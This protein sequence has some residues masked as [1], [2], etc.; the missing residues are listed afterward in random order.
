MRILIDLT[1]IIPYNYSGVTNYAFRLLEGFKQCLIRNDLTLLCTSQNEPFIRENAEEYKYMLF[2][3]RMIKK[4][5]HLTGILNQRRLDTIIKREGY[6]LFFS[7]FLSYGSL[8][9][10]SV[11]FVGVLHDAQGFSLKSNFLKQKAFDY[12]MQYLLSHLTKMVTISN[13]AKKNIKQVLPSFNIPIEVIYNSI[14]LKN[15]NSSIASF[16]K[17]PYILNVNTL[18]PY[19]NL[20]SLVRAFNLL[21]N[22][23]PHQLIVKAKRLPYWDNEILPFLI[24]HRIEK[25]VRL[26][27]ENLT[28]KKM[29]TLYSNASLFVSPSLM[30]GF[31]FTPIEAAIHGV[32]V[33]CTKESALFET[34]KGLLNYYAPPTSEKALSIKIL[35]VLSKSYS[36]ELLSKIAIEYTTYY[37]PQKQAEQFVNLFNKQ[38][39]HD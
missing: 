29:S 26:I 30:E 17:T 15:R 27:D 10:H 31:G 3:P 23:I 24:N 37:S 20:I 39:I 34:T 28:E 12:S 22:Q 4:I 16:I 13:F 7:P 11:P 38:I 9:C 5:P 19:K 2:N 8:Y 25:R 35:E 36:N 32:P 33:I 14:S 18:E 1:Y 21:K 6:E